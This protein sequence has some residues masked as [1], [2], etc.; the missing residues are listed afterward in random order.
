M[1][2]PL[3]SRKLLNFEYSHELLNAVNFSSIMKTQIVAKGVVH[4]EEKDL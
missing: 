2:V 3:Q 1:Q 4:V